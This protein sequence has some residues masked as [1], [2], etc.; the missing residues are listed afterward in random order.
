MPTVLNPCLYGA[1]HKATGQAPGIIRQGDTGTILPAGQGRAFTASGG[2]RYLIRCPVCE[3]TAQKRLAFQYLC[4]AVVQ[5]P[6]YANPVKFGRSMYRCVHNECQGGSELWKWL[7]DN[8]IFRPSLLDLSSKEVQIQKG[9]FDQ[10]TVTDVPLPKGVKSLLAASVPDF[11]LEY[12]IGRGHDPSYLYQ[13]FGILYAPRGS[14]W[15][16]KKT[17]TE[18]NPIEEFQ[19]LYSDHLLFPIYARRRMCGWQLRYVP[20]S[21]EDTEKGNL[22]YRTVGAANLRDALY[23]MDVA[24]FYPNVAI[25]EGAPDVWRCHELSSKGW[26][27]VGLLSKGFNLERAEICEILWGYGNRRG[28]IMLDSIAKDSQV[29]KQVQ[30]IVSYLRQTKAFPG[31][32]SIARL[33]EGDPGSTIDNKVLLDKLEGGERCS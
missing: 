8:K 24:K 5:L 6:Q 19:E 4:G 3:D 22:K 1:L 27:G 2:E 30:Q 10:G 20:I 29:E 32:L 23:N 21:P 25:V 14:T 16:E 7:K 13:K 31:G 33:D 15:L 9:V 28:C 26:T 18:G 12:L 11:V 17:D